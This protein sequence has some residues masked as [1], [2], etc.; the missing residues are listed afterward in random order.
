MLTEAKCEMFFSPSY[1]ELRNLLLP[2]QLNPNFSCLISDAA[3]SY[4]KA[5]LTLHPIQLL[6]IL[7]FLT[8]MSCRQCCAVTLLLVL[9]SCC[10]WSA[11]AH[12]AC[13]SHDKC[14][15]NKVCECWWSMSDMMLN[16]VTCCLMQCLEIERRAGQSS[17]DTVVR[18][19]NYQNV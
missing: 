13:H 14:W 8:P 15:L 6:N 19:H 16:S 5:V 1:V 3:T 4:L 10:V 9:P 2:I 7:S 17:C 11:C 18:R 12:H